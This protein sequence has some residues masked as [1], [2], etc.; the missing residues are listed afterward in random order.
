M[1]APSRSLLE[2]SPARFAAFFGVPVRPD[3]TILPVDRDAPCHWCC[4]WSHPLQVTPR[5]INGVTVPLTYVEWL[6]YTWHVL[7]HQRGV[8]LA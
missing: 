2:D 7:H 4:H 1:D 8:P 3:G 6:V 5:V